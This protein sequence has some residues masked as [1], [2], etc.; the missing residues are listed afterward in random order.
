MRHFH[1]LLMASSLLRSESLH[2]EDL[3]WLGV[4]ERAG[5]ASHL[6]PLRLTREVHRPALDLEAAAPVARRPA[7]SLSTAAEI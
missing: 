2:Q 7:G 5:R 3:A 4:T 6:G 1:G